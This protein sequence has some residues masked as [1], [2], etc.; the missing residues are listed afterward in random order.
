MVQREVA[1]RFF[2]APGDEG[3]RRRLGARPAR[4]GAHRLPSGRPH[5][6]PSAPERRLRARRLPAPRRSRTTT[7]RSSASCRR[8]SRTAARRSRTR[9]SSP[10]SRPAKMPRPRW[11]RSASTPASRAEALRPEQFAEL[12]RLLAMTDALAHGQDQPRARRRAASRRRQAR[13]GDRPAGPRPRRHDRRRARLRSPGHRFRGRHARER[14]ARGAG[15]GR[16][17]RA[18]LARPDREAHPRR[19]RPRR[20]ELGR[21][22]GAPAGE[23]HARRAA[24][25]RARCPR[26]P[27]GSAPTCP[28]SSPPGSSSARETAASSSR[29]TCRSTTRC[30]WSCRTARRRPRPRPCTPTSTGAAARRASTRGAPQLLEALRRVRAA[31]DLAALPRNDLAS[32]PLS[33][34][35]ERLGAFRAD[36][37]GAGP[38]VYGLFE[39]ESAARDAASALDGLGAA[40]VC[41]PDRGTVRPR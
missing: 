34:E 29:S 1:D 26:S 40:Q 20:R 6:L 15:G 9:S 39:T 32:S 36:V 16:G 27:R 25:P 14:C 30:C 8:R 12:A 2:A 37:S 7:R 18:L 24:C 41:A 4:G 33:A 22:D 17:R 10:A 11:P 13:G 3:L 21:G 5:G 31:R 28:S 19:C 35:L 23:R 38:T